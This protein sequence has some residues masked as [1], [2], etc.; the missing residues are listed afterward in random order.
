M[1]AFEFGGEA[2]FTDLLPNTLRGHA[3]EQSVLRAPFPEV[4]ESAGDS[5]GPG[6]FESRPLSPAHDAS[7]RPP[8]DLER[9]V[10]VDNHQL[11]V[12]PD[13]L[14]EPS[15]TS[16]ADRLWERIVGAP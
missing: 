2:L 15:A 16:Y 11:A 7:P 12:E 9:L 4:P 1:F 8:L 14:P 6:G 10:L 3:H 5:N 13:G